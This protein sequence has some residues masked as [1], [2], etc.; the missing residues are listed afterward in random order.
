MINHLT[1]N[2]NYLNKHIPWTSLVI[3]VTDG[4]SIPSM[5]NLVKVGFD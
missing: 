2:C 5:V 4:S 3:L 1:G